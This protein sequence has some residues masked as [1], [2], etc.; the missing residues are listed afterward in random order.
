MVQDEE[1]LCICRLLTGQVRCNWLHKLVRAPK[2]ACLTA[3]G[4]FSC[5]V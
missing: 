4:I 3:V 5:A 1:Q 2:S